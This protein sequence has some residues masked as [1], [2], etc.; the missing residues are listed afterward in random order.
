M[1]VSKVTHRRELKMGQIRERKRGEDREI[2]G[3]G[4]REGGSEDSWRNKIG[5]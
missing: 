3:E 5:V 2:R 4:E 1:D